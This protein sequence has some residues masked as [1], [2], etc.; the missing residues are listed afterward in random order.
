MLGWHAAMYTGLARKDWTLREIV[1]QLA[2]VLVN[3]EDA[4]R[5]RGTTGRLVSSESLH[6]WLTAFVYNAGVG[7][8]SA[9]VEVIDKTA[10]D[11][12]TSKCRFLPLARDCALTCLC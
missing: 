12:Q 4:V 1:L 8:L 2:D 7:L 6:H 10:L 3:E 11:R 5:S 9:I